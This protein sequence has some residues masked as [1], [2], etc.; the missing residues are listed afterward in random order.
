MKAAITLCNHYLTTSECL[1][2]TIPS[3]SLVIIR[4]EGEPESDSL[5]AHHSC[6]GFHAWNRDLKL[7]AGEVQEC[8]W[9]EPC[10]DCGCTF[11]Y[12]EVDKEPSLFFINGATVHCAEC[13]KKGEIEVY[14]AESVGCDWGE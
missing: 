8:T 2:K 3:G 11:S 14:D 13:A 10:P 5:V 7:I 1:E 4:E 12:V 9:F 6:G